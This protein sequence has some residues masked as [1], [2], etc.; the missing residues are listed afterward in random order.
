MRRLLILGIALSL[1]ALQPLFAAETPADA[2]A[3]NM[4]IVRDAIHAE[5]KLFIAENMG[6]TEAEAEKFW[7][8][9]EEF[10]NK[11]KAIVDRNLA[12]I[13]KYAE[14]YTAMTDPV[15]DKLVRDYLAIEK[16]AVVLRESYLPKFS[17]VLPA[18]KVARYY[19][20]ENKIQAVIHYDMAVEIPVIPV[21]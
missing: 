8:I 18:A 3:D 10:Q 7:P 21:E 5:K 12:L 1:L 14:A 6:L 11:W 16:D 2:P 17:A 9:Y 15:A 20:L 13:D 4:E 19:Q